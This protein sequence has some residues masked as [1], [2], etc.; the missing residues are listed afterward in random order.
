M[1]PENHF[2][3]SLSPAD[4]GRLKP[5]LSPIELDQN[6]V[7]AEPGHPVS[8]VL[9]PTGAV[10]SIITIMRDGR[11]VESRT[12]GRE[13]AFG[14]LH[15]LGARVSF[16]QVIVQIPGP[17]L[18]LAVSALAEAATVSP[19][20]VRA[21]VVHAQATIVQ[22]A[23][24]SACNALHGVEAR[25]CRWLVQT[26]DRLGGGVLPLTQEHLSIMLGVQR[27]TVTA[28]AQGLQERGLI[29]YSRGKIRIL[30]RDGLKSGACEC[31]LA[32]E[33]AVRDI[34]AGGLVC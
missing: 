10:I 17:A 32:T 14:L 34:L 1:G 2:L 8:H 21:I 13:S 6:A 24:T 27:T 23:Q 29:A 22:A 19:S 11:S 9:I 3:A 20:L 12:I 30:D 18:R 28:A 4:L 7:L 5:H 26:Q 15:A 16:E 25:L 33:E 31:L